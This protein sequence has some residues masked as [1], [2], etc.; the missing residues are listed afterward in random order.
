MALWA[1]LV[2][3]AVEVYL[4]VGVIFALAFVSFGIARVDP[5]AAGSSVWFRMLVVPGA[6]ALWPLLLSRWVRGKTAPEECN[7]HR[8]AAREDRA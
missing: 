5:S 1:L 2:V 7:A 4:A 3:R 6:V 8:R